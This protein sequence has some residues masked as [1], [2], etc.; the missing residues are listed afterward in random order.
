MVARHDLRRLLRRRLHR[1]VPGLPD[2]A[3]RPDR[4]LV[5]DHAGRHR[6]AAARLRRGRAVRP[7]RPLRRASSRCRWSLL[8]VGTVP[9]LGPG[10]QH[11]SP[12]G[13][14]GRATCSSP[15][16]LGG[17]DGAWAFANLGVLVALLIGFLGTLALRGAAVRAQE[18]L[19]P[20]TTGGLARRHRHAAR[21]RRPGLA[22]GGAPASPR[23][24]RGSGEL[25][26]GLRRPRASGPGSSR[27]PK[28]AG[29]WRAY[30]ETVPVRPAAAGRRALPS[31][32]TTRGAHPVVDATTFGK[33]GPELAAR[34]RATGR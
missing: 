26:G 4:G 15:F 12:A 13:W 27:P 17:K 31:W 24:G 32:W 20:V 9:R 22:L 34:R 28:P 11:A 5:R 1:P 6:A 18:T 29:A 25:R 16:G 8:V 2:H 23:S 19:S 7:A 21:L 14:T 30:Y 3:R 10:H 33:W